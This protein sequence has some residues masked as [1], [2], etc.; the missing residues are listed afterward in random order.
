[1]HGYQLT[2]F[3]QQDRKHEGLSLGAWLVEEACR[4]GIGGATL[5]TA[6]EG[7]GPH[8]KIHSAHFFELADQPVEVMMAV[9]AEEAVRL[10]ERLSQE[11][12]NIFYIKI[13]IEF[14]MT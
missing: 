8:R 4:L 14:G 1:M 13:P 5:S 11:S 9:H 7:F 6:A 2:F 3:T 10:F 12:I